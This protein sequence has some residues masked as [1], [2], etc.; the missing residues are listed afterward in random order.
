[1]QASKNGS[2]AP[3]LCQLLSTTIFDSKGLDNYTLSTPNSQNNKE[4]EPEVVMRNKK[5]TAKRNPTLSMY[6]NGHVTKQFKQ[7]IYL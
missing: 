6:S 7:S 3:M 5:D 4:N 1:M 2:Q